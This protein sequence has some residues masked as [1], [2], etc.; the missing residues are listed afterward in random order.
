MIER[1]NVH[2]SEH[3][4]SNNHKSKIVLIIDSITANNVMKDNVYESLFN[5]SL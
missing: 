4:Y 3:A 2:C 1:L 5:V